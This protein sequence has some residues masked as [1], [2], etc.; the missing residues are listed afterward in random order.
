MNLDNYVILA[1]AFGL[2]LLIG[3]ERYKDRKEDKQRFAGARTFAIFAVL[4]AVCGLLGSPLFTALTFTALFA[5]IAIGYFRESIQGLGMTTE[6]T[7]LLT[8]WLGYLLHIHESLAASIAIVLVILLA[9]KRALHGFVRETLSDTEFYDTLK[10]LAV[11]IVILPLLP[12]HQMGPYEFF[13]P[14]RVWYL[15]I[16]VSTISYSGYVLIRTLGG[17][18]GIELNA[19]T[20]G[21]VS[22]T[23]VTLALS[24]QARRL[25]ECVRLFGVAGVMAN[26]VQLPRLLVLLA[27]VDL[28]LAS[29]MAI[30]LIA[31]SVAGL[32]GAILL[33]NLKRVWDDPPDVDLLLQNPYSLRQALT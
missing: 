4:G 5:I 29:R 3:I 27:L 10:F 21:L 18:R 6:V 16:A 26:A 22:T 17:R 14:T 23:A 12:D 24:E 11:I 13:N 2:G 9:S 20:G 8:F 28:D 1:E 7:A 33:A 25:P 30:P 19:V 32:G 31:A 15:V